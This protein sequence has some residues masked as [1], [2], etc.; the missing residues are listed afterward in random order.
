MILLKV[1]GDSQCPPPPQDFTM[2]PEVPRVRRLL[3]YE[4]KN[5]NGSIVRLLFLSYLSHLSIS[6]YCAASQASQKA[7]PIVVALHYPSLCGHFVPG[8]SVAESGGQTRLWRFLPFDDFHLCLHDILDLNI[9]QES[10]LASSSS[11]G[12][13]KQCIEGENSPCGLPPP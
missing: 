4:G 13:P 1:H 2:F 8:L 6:L 5:G 9:E 12:A 3:Q 10:C 7:A 11:F